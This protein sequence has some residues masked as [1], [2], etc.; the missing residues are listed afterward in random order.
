MVLINIK[1]LIEYCFVNRYINKC[2]M[3][4]KVKNN[5]KI[6]YSNVYSDLI[7]ILKNIEEL[8]NMI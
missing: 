6:L 5:L 8:Y 7:L 3:S 4:N 1:I 2:S